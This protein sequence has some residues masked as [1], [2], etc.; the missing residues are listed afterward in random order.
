[1]EA[2]INYLAVMAETND[3]ENRYEIK[4]L[5]TNQEANTNL[6]AQVSVGSLSKLVVKSCYEILINP[7]GYKVEH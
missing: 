1:M 3:P 4:V 7:N 6:F 2:D 5:T